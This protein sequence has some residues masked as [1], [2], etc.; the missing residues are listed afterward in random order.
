MTDPN[1]TAVPRESDCS[2][3]AQFEYRC[4]RCGCVS[5][6]PCCSPDLA[7]WILVEVTMNG[8]GGDVKKGGRVYAHVSHSC[9]D[10]GEGMADLIGY[11]VIDTQNAPPCP[12]GGGGADKGG[13][14]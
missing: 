7:R 11:R 10:G 14:S 4:R 2:I 12:S 9:K 3:E 8:A 13:R 6:N 5:R 1:V